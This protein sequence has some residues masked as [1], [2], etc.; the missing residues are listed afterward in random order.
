VTHPPLALTLG[1]PAGIGPEISLKAWRSL[2]HGPVCFVA[3]G[4]ARPWLETAQSLGLPC[5]EFVTDAQEAL[6]V[7]PHALPVFDLPETSSTPAN[8][9]ASVEAAVKSALK[10]EVSGI[11]TNPISKVRLYQ[12]GFSFP[13]HTEFIAHLTS[14]IQMEGPRGPVMMLSGGGLRTALVTTHTPLKSAIKALSSGSVVQTTRVTAYAL[15]RDFG[16]NAPRLALAGL[17]P[18]AGENGALGHEEIDILAPALRTLAA[19]GLEILGPLSPDTMFHKEARAQYD[20]AICLYHDQGLIPVK[21]LDFHGGV[22]ITLGLPIVRTSPDHGVA[23]DI[24]G[25]GVAR[26]DSLIA[27]LR[28]AHDIATH[29]RERR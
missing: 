6:R 14:D 26:A 10:D 7:F 15:R 22:N 28:L 25:Q 9:V 2:R 29:R 1:D 5:P 19:E 24:A 4:H 23:F 21:T 17:N 27:A 12:E 16:F 3:M 8:A 20:A 11:V 18:H 13:G